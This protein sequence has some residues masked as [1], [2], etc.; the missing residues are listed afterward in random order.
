MSRYPYPIPSREEILDM[1]REAKGS[2]NAKTI[3][4]ALHVK[5]GEVEGLTRRLDAM[6]RDGQLHFTEAGGYTIKNLVKATGDGSVGLAVTDGA[7]KVTVRKAERQAFFV[8]FE[9]G[10][11]EIMYPSGSSRSR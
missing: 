9:T 2:Q 5:R 4:K 10:T 11:S 1:L 3:A 6:Q 8:D 7:G